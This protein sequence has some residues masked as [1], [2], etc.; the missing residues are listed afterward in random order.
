MLMEILTDFPDRLRSGKLVF[1]GEEHQ[2]MRMVSVRRTDRDLIVRLEGL[3]TPEEANMLRGSTVYIKA[4]GLPVL[5]E[6]QYYHHQ[7]L[8]LKV[9]DEAGQEIGKLD[10]I[11]ET[12]ANDV[13]VVQTLE[14]KELLLPATDEVILKIDLEQQV[15]TVHLLEYY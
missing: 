9:V 3:H 14:N 7:L 6:G 1:V 5:P 12:G 10:H 13:Y 15:M 8:G 4:Q 11:I 2:L